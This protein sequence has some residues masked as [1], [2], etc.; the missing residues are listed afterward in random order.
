MAHIRNISELI[1]YL[2]KVKAQHGDIAVCHSE[3]HEYWG[4]YDSFLTPDFN[5]AVSEHA[6]PDGPKSGKSVK[7][8][9]SD[10]EQSFKTFVVR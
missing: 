6:Q 10:H 9:N 8:R 2:E 5:L 1:S 7:A 3:Q 4:S